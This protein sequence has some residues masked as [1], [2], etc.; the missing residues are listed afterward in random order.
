M[1]TIQNV[2]A[3]SLFFVALAAIVA[4]CGTLFPW[5]QKDE[6]AQVEEEIKGDA[7]S[8][9][10]LSWSLNPYH[11]SAGGFELDGGK[12]GM[13]SVKR[14]G[15][16][17]DIR[18]MANFATAVYRQKLQ[19]K[20]KGG[21]ALTKGDV[22][23]INFCIMAQISAINAYSTTALNDMLDD[24]DIPTA[25][26]RKMQLMDVYKEP[27]KRLADFTQQVE[28]V[29]DQLDSEFRNSNGVFRKK[30][31]EWGGFFNDIDDGV[32]IADFEKIQSSSKQKI[33]DFQWRQLWGYVPYVNL[34]T[35]FWEKELHEDVALRPYKNYKAS[36]LDTA[37]KWRMLNNVLAQNVKNMQMIFNDCSGY[38]EKA[39]D[40]KSI[41]EV[42]NIRI[43]TDNELRSALSLSAFVFSDLP[44][45]V[46]CKQAAI[47][48]QNCK[49]AFD[50]DE[51]EM[52]VVM[53]KFFVRASD[54][55][56]LLEIKSLYTVDLYKQLVN[57]LFKSE[58]GGDRF[59]SYK[60]KTKFAML[61]QLNS[62]YFGKNTLK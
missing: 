59:D 10:T 57:D 9:V 62:D 36:D 15:I 22:H 12:D 8:E 20:L 6:L 24:T 38:L 34:V 47:G 30:I 16:D 19:A 28:D 50:D 61:D 54:P 26:R 27:D 13:L 11:I 25:Q 35:I 17:N 39:T 18:D 53:N 31:R 55:N 3:K 46:F 2:S 44:L 51:D 14:T 37:A 23:L 33:G 49:A 4:G 43:S 45:T 5:G 40:A 41:Q 32:L 56:M 58:L 48:I 21:E 7:T 52:E 29:C 60:E 42:D 1:S